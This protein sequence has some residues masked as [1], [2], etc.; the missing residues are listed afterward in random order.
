MAA[1]RRPTPP[2][3]LPREDKEEC[4]KTDK[5]TIDRRGMN[6]DRDKETLRKERCQRLL[7]D[8]SCWSTV[9]LPVLVNGAHANSSSRWLKSKRKR[10]QQHQHQHDHHHPQQTITTST[11]TSSQN[12]SNTNKS[13][14]NRT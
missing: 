10:R 3:I 13:G 14:A 9:R 5:H 8:F 7:F 6:T 4:D 11:S 2:C 1:S 12:S